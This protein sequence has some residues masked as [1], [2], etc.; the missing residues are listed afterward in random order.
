MDHLEPESECRAEP[1]AHNAAGMVALC[2]CCGQIH[3]NLQYLTLRFEPEAFDEL[4]AL[5]AQAQRRMAQRCAQT[6]RGEHADAMH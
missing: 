4:A 3:L 6:S 1:M 2:R 5:L